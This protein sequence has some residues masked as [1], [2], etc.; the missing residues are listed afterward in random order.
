MEN[1][2]ASCTLM[3]EMGYPVYKADG[4]ETNVKL[5]TPD[6][7]EIFKEIGEY[8][9]RLADFTIQGKNVYFTAL[10][11]MGNGEFKCFNYLVFIFDKSSIIFH[12]IPPNTQIFS[13]WVLTRI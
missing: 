3:I 4:S 13:L 5:T 2:T 8:E 6:D 12:A 9:D 10:L 11:N 1:T 7:I